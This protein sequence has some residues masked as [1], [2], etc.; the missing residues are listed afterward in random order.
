MDENFYK[1]EYEYYVE[2]IITQMKQNGATPLQILAQRAYYSGQEMF[3]KF[4][5][6]YDEQFAETTITF[7]AENDNEE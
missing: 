1:K 2:T 7:I 4:C 3:E 6:M 5:D